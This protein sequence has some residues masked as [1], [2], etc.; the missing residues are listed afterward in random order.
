MLGLHKFHE[1][2]KNLGLGLGLCE[3]AVCANV[4]VSSHLS[5]EP[6]RLGFCSATSPTSAWWETTAKHREHL[7]VA[8]VHSAGRGAELEILSL[9]LW[10][11]FIFQMYDCK[12]SSFLITG[13]EKWPQFH[14]VLLVLWL[15]SK[16]MDG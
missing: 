5:L 10:A 11:N 13:D 4:M 2:E 8:T 12:Q 3:L 6:P 14:S 15:I 16:A 7:E 1:A 9:T